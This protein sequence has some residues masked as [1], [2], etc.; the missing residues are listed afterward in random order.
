MTA[1][2]VSIYDYPPNYRRS[3]PHQEPAT[4]TIL[5]M[6]RAD[7]SLEH[8][9]REKARDFECKIRRKY[10]LDSEQSPSAERP[11]DSEE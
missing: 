4:I 8:R 5:P 2:I 1:K 6:I 7:R 3:I 9:N 10:R 11:C